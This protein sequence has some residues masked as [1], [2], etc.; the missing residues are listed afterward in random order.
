[1]RKL[2]KSIASKS[3]LFMGGMIIRKELRLKLLV[4]GILIAFSWKL[5]EKH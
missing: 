2:L 5:R 1:M 3:N 4:G